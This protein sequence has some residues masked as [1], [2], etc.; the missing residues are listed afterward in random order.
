MKYIFENASVSG[1]QRIYSGLKLEI[2][3]RSTTK[4][5][6]IPARHA[7]DVLQ[8]LKRNHPAVKAILVS[9]ERKASSEKPVEI[10]APEAPA[11]A[12]EE[13]AAA[14][15]AEPEAA[16]EATVEAPEDLEAPEAAAPSDDESLSPEE[17]L[18][19]PEPVTAVTA[20]AIAVEVAK[21]EPKPKKP[22][23]PRSGGK[24]K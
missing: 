1:V 4:P 3:G 22:R 20:I 5:I 13:V 23:K 11:E 15:E 10:V 8:H 16:V 2:P 18:P 9:E 14:T 17:I 12:E 7:A 24:K 19:P 6:E 21:S